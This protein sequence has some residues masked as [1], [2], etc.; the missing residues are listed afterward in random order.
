[1]LLAKCGKNIPAARPII[2]WAGSKRRQL[3]K[4]LACVPQTYGRYF[5]PFAGSACLFLALRPRKAILGDIIEELIHTYSVARERPGDVATAL[6]RMPRHTSYYYTLR[7]K[8]PVDLDP[9]GRAARFI[10]LNRNCFNGIYRTNKCG[11][12]NVPWGTRTGRNPSLKEFLN[13]ATTFR[14]AELRCGDF[15]DCL[16]DIR[17]GDFVYLDPPYS[18]SH[19]PSSGEYTYEC[20]A[21]RDFQRFVK[22]LRHADKLGAIL[23]LSFADDPRLR[24]SFPQW[25][26]RVVLARRDV[27][28]LAQY[29]LI[30][31]EVIASNK[32]LPPEL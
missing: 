10:Y 32:P 13:W 22:L 25:H 7:A 14:S 17:K 31:T 11:Q 15:E 8:V 4:L 26:Y 1:M 28:S 29:R 23:L 19:R 3:P 24:D 12:F 27:A 30:E 20:F 18:S 2:R 6:F 5:E 16:R 9:V 21:E